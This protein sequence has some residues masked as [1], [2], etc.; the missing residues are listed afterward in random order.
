MGP[1]LLLIIILGS[2]IFIHELGHFLMA[3]KAGVHIYEFA[4]GFGPK[5]WSRVG[6]KDKVTYSLRMFPIGGFVQMAGEVYEDDDKIPKSK[7][8]CNK[9]WLQRI[10]VICAG[11]VFNFILALILL[12][13]VALG[14]GYTEQRSY[15]GSVVD[16]YP[17]K[18][19]GI[20]AGDKII[21]VNGKTTNTWDMIILRVMMNKSKSHTFLVKKAD[22]RDITYE[23][24]PVKEKNKDGQE[25]EVFGFTSSNKEYKGFTNAIKYAITRFS[26]IISTMFVTIGGLFSGKIALSNLA[27]P[28]GMYSIVDQTAKYGLNNVISLMALLSINLGFINI[29]PFPAFDGGRATFLII[30]KIIGRPIN[31]KIENIMH[32]VFFVLLMGLMI[33]IT[34]QDILKLF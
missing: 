7:F 20:E 13:I 18:E 1:L 19:A 8:M 12:F 11:V 9:T 25:V 29:L 6:K 22:G 31:K 4:L 34:I 32:A 10:T 15:V 23:M 28:V 27:G 14:W 16:G 3:K 26:S 2:L 5:V 17:A 33:L 24:S 30:E 21:A